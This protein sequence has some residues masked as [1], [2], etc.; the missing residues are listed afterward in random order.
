MVILRSCKIHEC[1]KLS[2]EEVRGHREQPY[3]F[4]GQEGNQRVDQEQ[5]AVFQIPGVFVLAEE[6][7]RGTQMGQHINLIY[8]GYPA[9]T[10]LA[11]NI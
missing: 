7:M 1:T 11:T 3:Q 5:G 4:G 6:S 9:E 10:H 2:P 8:S